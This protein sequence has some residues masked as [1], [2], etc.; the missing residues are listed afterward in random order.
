MKKVLFGGTF[1]IFH[2]MHLDSIRKAKATGD[3][4]IMMVNSDRLVEE[5]KGK[6]PTFNQEERYHKEFKVC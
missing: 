3:Y 2:W 6:K 4:L 1:D 5:Y